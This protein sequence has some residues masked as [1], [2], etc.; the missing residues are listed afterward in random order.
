[1]NLITCI[2]TATVCLTDELSGNDTYIDHLLSPKEAG[3]ST[4]G[5]NR[6]PAKKDICL[7]GIYLIS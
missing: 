5:N 2:A 1:L 3:D 7:E 4:E 6:S